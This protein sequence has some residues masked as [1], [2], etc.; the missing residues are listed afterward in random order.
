MRRPVVLITGSSGG[1][2]RALC[3]AFAARG[4]DVIAHT[5]SAGQAPAGFATV[6][7]DLTDPGSARH[8]LAQL[9]AHG[10]E[11]DIVVCNAAVGHYGP[12]ASLD[13]RRL[14]QLLEVNTWSPIA[15]AH[16]L[17]PGLRRRRGT[18]AFISS[19]AAAV[20]APDYAAYA[21]SKAAL[22][23]FARNL[24]VELAGEV[25]C[26]TLRPGGIRTDLHTRS[27]VPV[28]TSGAWRLAD[29]AAVADS[30]AAQVLARRSGAV[31]LG[32]ALTHWAGRHLEGLLDIALARRPDVTRARP[33]VPSGTQRALVTGA[34][35]GIGL[36]LTRALI[37][38]GADVVGVD[39]DAERSAGATAELG[40]RLRIVAADLTDGAG[41]AGL[42][43][44]LAALGPFDRVV[45]NAGIN[46][47]GAF[48]TS[49]L[50]AQRRVFDVN[51]RAPLQLTTALLAARA[52]QPGAR[53]VFMSSLSH[54][55]GYPGAAVYAATKDGLAHFAR[56]LDAALRPNGIGTLRVHP[57]PTRTAH[58]ARYS[59]DNRREARRM[60]PEALA[61][62][63]LRA[64]ERGDRVLVPGIGNRLFAELGRWLPGLSEAVLKRT[65][66]EKMTAPER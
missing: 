37:A 58:A 4:C 62:H 2:G 56:S 61:A 23:G 35:D 30:L 17:L 50:A 41:L 6:A 20:P 34:A 60:P 45:Q 47:V 36:A 8:I 55:A 54:Y 29:A 9:E 27:G 59:P 43:R 42:A 52:L 22:D 7:A 18:L 57:G 63:I 5:R 65:L 40:S 66:L 14:D 28:E 39:V 48:A 3:A 51:L 38:S 49:D 13:A 32:T 10:L 1:L 53:L 12:P 21:A 64:V 46:A 11:P 24:R 19:V 33:H 15:L 31:G 16:A 26:L 44:E 25:A